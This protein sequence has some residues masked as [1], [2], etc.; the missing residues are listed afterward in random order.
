MATLSPQSTTLTFGIACLTAWYTASLFVRC[1]LD[2]QHDTLQE[3]WD[4]LK[5]I[6]MTFR[7]S[8]LC[9]SS[10]HDR[11]QRPP[12]G[13]PQ[14]TPCV[15]PYSSLCFRSCPSF[16]LLSEASPLIRSCRVS[17]LTRAAW[18]AA[19]AAWIWGF[20]GGCVLWLEGFVGCGCVVDGE[21]E[22]RISSTMRLKA[23]SSVC[24]EAI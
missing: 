4:V 14:V 16:S 12:L 11:M 9:I 7:T 15:T 5:T 10:L 2:S 21:W 19:S 17:P 6:F 23:C 8:Y 18:C 13:T 22:E 20:G 1:R 24:I 3:L